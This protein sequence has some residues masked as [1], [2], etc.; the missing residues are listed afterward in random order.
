MQERSM[1]VLWFC[2]SV[3]KSVPSRAHFFFSASFGDD[4]CWLLPLFIF[5]SLSLSLS[6]SLARS[7]ARSLDLDTPGFREMGVVFSSLWH[8]MFPGKEYK[9]VMVKSEEDEKRS[10]RRQRRPSIACV[11]SF[12]FLSFCPLLQTLGFL[13]RSAAERFEKHIEMMR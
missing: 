11:A 6:L 3:A 1:S 5:R 12:A 9:I 4:R 8:W 10:R 13:S 2:F 7:L